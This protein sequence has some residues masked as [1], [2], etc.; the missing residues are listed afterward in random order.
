MLKH[1]ATVW[2]YRHFWLS[3]V[4]MD[5]KTRYRRSILGVGWS[6]MNPIMMTVVFCFVFGAWFK[7]AD[8]RSYGPYFLAGLTLFSFVRDSAWSG[9]YTFF[10]SENYI[11]QCPL[12]LTI[13]TL[14]TVLGAGIHF[15]ISL[16]VTFLAVL[17]LMPEHALRTLS[18]AWVL[19]P[20]VIMLFMFCWSISVLASYMTVFF[21]DTVQMLEVLFQILFFLTPIMYPRQ[22]I[23]DRG[24]TI[25]L[26]INPIVTFLDMIREPLLTGQLP[27]QWVYMKAAIMVTTAGSMAIGTIVWLEKKMIFHL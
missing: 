14:R 18:I 17:I 6:L 19:L 24:L 3:M 13:Y 21:H 5:L 15:G 12:P 8:W 2:R 9:C 25:L 23:V 11:R 1:L 10:K 16:V 27:N 26:Q 7:Q 4:R 22:M 20:G